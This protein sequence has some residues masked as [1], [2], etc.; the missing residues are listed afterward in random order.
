MTPGFEDKMI[1]NPNETNADM[2]VCKG[3]SWCDGPYYL[4]LLAVKITLP[5]LPVHLRVLG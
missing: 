1:A 5:I 4:S 3:G 2:R